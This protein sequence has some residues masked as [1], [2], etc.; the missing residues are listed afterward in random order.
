MIIG[1]SIVVV[2][3]AILMIAVNAEAFCE[4]PRDMRDAMCFLVILVVAVIFVLVFVV[5]GF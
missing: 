2:L 1:M 5:K 4:A 3:F